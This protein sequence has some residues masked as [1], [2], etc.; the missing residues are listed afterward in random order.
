MRYYAYCTDSSKA[1]EEDLEN[2]VIYYSSKFREYGIPVKNSCEGIASSYI[3]IK[4]CPWCGENLPESKRN[5]WF[6]AL[7]LLG[8]D[9]PLDQE[10]PLDFQTSAWYSKECSE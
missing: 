9:S 2:K 7:E 5:E 3:L 4:Y 8:Y 10:I 1:S 6:D